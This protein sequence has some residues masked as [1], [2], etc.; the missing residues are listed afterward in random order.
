[1]KKLPTLTGDSSVES[2]Y[3][4]TPLR[5]LH[6]DILILAEKFSL[7]HFH[8]KK[9][10]KSLILFQNIPENLPSL[11]I[12]LRNPPHPDVKLENFY[13]REFPMPNF[14]PQ[15][16]SGWKISLKKT[17]PRKNPPYYSYPA[18]N[19]SRTIP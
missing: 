2:S 9:K 19:F 6:P 8:L 18:E 1:M 11:G 12:S 3:H 10:I 4:V 14:F 15:K 16:I 5:K 13:L 7:A 17:T